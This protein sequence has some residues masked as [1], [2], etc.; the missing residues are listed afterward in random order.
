MLL[1]YSIEAKHPDDFVLDAIGI[2]S[3]IVAQIITEQAT[4]LRNPP[5]SIGAL[6]DT[7]RAND[8][9]QSVALIRES[10]GY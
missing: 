7:L 4:A 2:S 8:L 6:L 3:G 10:F 9:P 1:P 5:S